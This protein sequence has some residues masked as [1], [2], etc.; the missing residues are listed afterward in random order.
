MQKALSITDEVLG[1]DSLMSARYRATLSWIKL[2]EGQYKDSELL[3][4][5]S[6][7][8]L[9]TACGSVDS[10]VRRVKNYPIA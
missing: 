1:A 3:A 6:L 7:T 8:Q 9:E 5:N 4:N 10:S 2:E